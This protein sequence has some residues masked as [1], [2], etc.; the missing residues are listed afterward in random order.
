MTNTRKV[1]AAE[2]LTAAQYAERIQ[3]NA[4]KFPRYVIER[5]A[6]AT[7]PEERVSGDAPVSD[8][9]KSAIETV[10][11]LFKGVSSGL[12]NYDKSLTKLCKSAAND[13]YKL[14]APQIVTRVLELAKGLPNSD[15]IK[16]KKYFELWGFEFLENR[17]AKYTCCGITNISALAERRVAMKEPTVLQAYAKAKKDENAESES[18]RVERADFTEKT[19]SAASACEDSRRRAYN[20]AKDGKSEKQ[21]KAA[22]F[23]ML[24]AQF[25]SAAEDVVKAMAEAVKGSNLTADALAAVLK[26]SILKQVEASRELSGKRVV[27]A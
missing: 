19:V 16:V 22:A 9:V 2:N 14:R 26:A 3:Q 4:G 24:E 13:A 7:N 20:N 27:K 21:K 23:Y 17:D 6:P 11:S 25:A 18:E 15:R 12:W 5:P 1:F 10:E 8:A